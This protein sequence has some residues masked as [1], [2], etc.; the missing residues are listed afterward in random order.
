MHDLHGAQLTR[1]LMQNQIDNTRAA[2]AKL[3]QD[4][5]SAINQLSDPHHKSPSPLQK[6]VLP[7]HALSLT[8]FTG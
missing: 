7:V 8:C 1:L 3:T 4:P 5:V 2:A 6:D